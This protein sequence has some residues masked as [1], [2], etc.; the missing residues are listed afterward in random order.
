MRI[1]SLA[2]SN[3]E[4]LFA[5]GLGDQVVGVTEYC[6]Y[7]PL[8][9]KKPRF[10]GWVNADI[11]KVK[12]AHPDV[13]FTSTFL[14]D[15]IVSQLEQAGLNVVHVDPKTLE[16][17]FDSIMTIAKACDWELG[18]KGLVRVIRKRMNEIS[19][20][21]NANAVEEKAVYVEEWPMTASGNW[22][23]DLMRLAKCKS[24]LKPGEISR[25]VTLDEV[26]AFNPE[27]MI[28]SWCG[29]GDRVPK[30]KITERE[31]WP[32]PEEKI[33]ILHD[34]LLNRPGPRLV[35]GLETLAKIVH[36]EVFNA[37]GKT[38]R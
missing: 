23:P 21:L 30:E 33:Y 32:I 8:A 37:K 24:M 4:I 7:P 26:K 25:K 15:K 1:L 17:V 27:Q 38:T 12:Q 13:I 36:P 34:S 3:T 19:E 9:T 31:N 22:V 5:L 18:G 28:V 16:E 11:E 2:P 14:Q 35:H 29:C 6:D 20:Q 10:G